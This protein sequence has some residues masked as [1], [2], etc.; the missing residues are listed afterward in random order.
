MSMPSWRKPLAL[1]LCCALVIVLALPFG[2]FADPI[3]SRLAGD[4]EE[5]PTEEASE[6]DTLA[7]HDSDSEQQVA[8]PLSASDIVITANGET[9]IELSDTTYTLS[10]AQTGSGPIDADTSI[11]ADEGV[12][13]TLVVEGSGS[14]NSML[15]RSSDRSAGLDCV[16]EA[17]SD[18]RVLNI[19]ETMSLTIRGS[20]DVSSAA[21]LDT[22]P[23]AFTGIVDVDGSLYLDG[24]ELHG[25][26]NSSAQS[27][28]FLQIRDTR[29]A[30]AAPSL[31]LNGSTISI[32][33]ESASVYT[34]ISVQGQ[35]M[36]VDESSISAVRDTEGP[37]V[38][39]AVTGSTQK[40]GTIFVDGSSY[41]ESDGGGGVGV[42]WRAAKLGKEASVVCEGAEQG[43]TIFTLTIGAPDA[44][45]NA[46]I[47]AKSPRVALEVLMATEI[48]GAGPSVPS[49][50]AEAID[51][52]TTE[53]SI[54]LIIRR[55]VVYDTMI[56]STVQTESPVA[57][58]IQIYDVH[59]G[60]L[61]QPED[62]TPQAYF[63]NVTLDST[64]SQTAFQMSAS[65]DMV[66]AGCD[67]RATVTR[68]LETTG[69]ST[70]STGFHTFNGSYRFVDSTVD[71]SGGNYG[72]I[73]VLDGNGQPD[74]YSTSV[75]AEDGSDLSFTGCLSGIVVNKAIEANSASTI[76]G[77]ATTVNP[78]GTDE[79]IPA[80]YVS[81]PST[82]TNEV[83]ALGGTITEVYP[84]HIGREIATGIG[85]EYCPYSTAWNL[86]QPSNYAWSAQAANVGLAASE[87]GVYTDPAL[88][89]RIPN[90]TVTATRTASSSV[91]PVVLGE[92]G[93]QHNI[94]LVADLGARATGKVTVSFEPNGGSPKPADQ[95]LD[96]GD[97]AVEP[98]GA[99]VPTRSGYRFEGWYADS[100]L[101]VL[102]DFDAAVTSDMTLYAKWAAEQPGTTGATQTKGGS[103]GKGTVPRTGDPI[104]DA[105][106]TAALV[107][108]LCIIVAMS[109]K[110]RSRRN[111]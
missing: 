42:I 21:V 99:E 63:D 40:G 6:P 17:G 77:T 5:A 111:S 8:D 58:G 27:E 102:W 82:G 109:S 35:D 37:G 91:E 57:T 31:V 20:L 56:Q 46:T 97:R 44:P 106:L 23:E 16:I 12:S 80:V 55:P 7:A 43:G 52:Q 110:V 24:G 22:S 70:Q 9:T 45:S 86:V 88:E 18:I 38:G 13:G 90:V 67:V 72:W 87:Q 61:G 50:T 108:V 34:L 47:E 1:G 51:R 104:L 53:G 48:Y 79:S 25:Y 98:T 15:L 92:T 60:Y 10:G 76:T 96:R 83:R 105:A 29:Q 2:A 49:I 85:A 95:V 68:S 66:F 84:T 101:T 75:Y 33:T 19:V 107:G 74:L 32:Q 39:F 54:G 93:S 41:I 28:S 71:A 100:A 4:R 65:D 59:N 94:V 89:S 3:S 26:A 73:S 62:P 11:V 14:L 81:Q 103:T 36:Y 64:A 78:L 30:D 69:T